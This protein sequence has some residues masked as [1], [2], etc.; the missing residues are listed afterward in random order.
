MFPTLHRRNAVQRTGRHVLATRKPFLEVLEDRTVLSFTYPNFASIS[1][2]QLNSSAKQSGDILRLT[3]KGGGPAGSAWN[4]A[5]QPVEEG[6]KTSFAFRISP[7]SQEGGD[8]F[9]FVIQ[10]IFPRIGLVRSTD[11]VLEALG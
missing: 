1:G 11:A 7:G 2:L 6:F 5:Q 9:A 8:G 4:I 10:N 3:D